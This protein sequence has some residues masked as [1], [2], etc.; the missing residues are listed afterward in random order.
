MARI[1]QVVVTF[2]LFSAVMAGFGALLKVT[3]LPGL[4]WLSGQIG[5]NAV[6]A[7]EGALFI[8]GSIYVYRGTTAARRAG[9]SD[10]S[11]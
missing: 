11:F 4:A 8:A 2:A 9:R 3:L 5:A 7:I 6:L 10:R 1:V